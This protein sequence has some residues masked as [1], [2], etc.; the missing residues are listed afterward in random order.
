VVKEL[1]TD[2]ARIDWRVHLANR[3]AGWYEFQ[4]AMDLKGK[5]DENGERP[6]LAI[7]VRHRNQKYAGSRDDLVIDPGPRKISGKDVHGVSYHFDT[8]RFVRKP[9]YLGELRTDSEGRLLVSPR[10]RRARRQ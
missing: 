4:N 1:T 6:D 7:P 9:V 2:D 8:G 5:P 3:K 10:A